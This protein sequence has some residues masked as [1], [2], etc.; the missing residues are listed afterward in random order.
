MIAEAVNLAQPA[1]DPPHQADP[2]S[3]EE[4]AKHLAR[5]APV[6]ASLDPAGR[7]AIWDLA[8]RSQFTVRLG[9]AEAMN[10]ATASA[11]A[12]WADEAKRLRS[13]GFARRDIQR[14]GEL[15]GAVAAGFMD[16]AEGVLKDADTQLA[17]LEGLIV[18][19]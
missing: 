17:R 11:S 16:A 2:R 19:R 12:R 3:P 13:R 6:V 15:V 5:L 14:L 10:T 8:V 4:T 9:L 1:A 7:Q 18:Y